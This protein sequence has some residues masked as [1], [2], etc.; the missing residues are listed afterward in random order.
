MAPS[1]RVGL[2]RKHD[3]RTEPPFIADDWVRCHHHPESLGELIDVVRH[4]S[5]LEKPFIRP[6]GSSWSL[7]EAVAN[8]DYEYTL[9]STHLLHET[10]DDVIPSCLT[11]AARD[12]LVGQQ[13]VPP[14]AAAEH[15]YTYY[16]VEAGCRIHDLYSRLDG[17]DPAWPTP[18]DG[19]S[20]GLRGPWAMPTLGGAGGQTIAGAISTS[21]HGGDQ[22]R[23]PIADAVAAIHLVAAGGMQFWIQRKK[24]SA[25]V[26]A[27]LC[28][29]TALQEVYRETSMQAGSKLEV[30]EDDRLFN[31]A[32]VAVGRMGVIYSYVLRVVHAYGLSEEREH[33]EWSE[34][35]RRLLDPADRLY[36]PWFLQVVVNPLPRVEF[37]FDPFQLGFAE[38]GHS[39]W[40]TTAE[41]I[42]VPEPLPEDGRNWLG[43]AQRAGS[44]AGRAP[45]VDNR[46]GDLYA[47]ACSTQ[48]PEVLLAATGAIATA[49]FLVSPIAPPFS[50]ILSGALGTTAGWLADLALRA[51]REGSSIGDAI[52]EI[53]NSAVADDKSWVLNLIAEAVIASGQAPTSRPHEDLGY[54]IQDRYNYDDVSCITSADSIEVAFDADTSAPVDFINTGVIPLARDLLDGRLTGNRQA[55]AGYASM[56]W[57]A[58]TEA[59]IG[60]QRWDRSCIIEVAGFKTFSGSGPYLDALEAH[61]KTMGGTVHWGQRN[62]L[63]RT[64]VNNAYASTIEDWRA[65]LRTLSAYGEPST[66]SSRYTE[67]AGLE[68]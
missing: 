40:I 56:R 54:A 10:L 4:D 6:V 19:L 55:F 8:R 16:H 27:P 23:P 62:S 42:A 51:E 7:S 2:R 17:Q 63:T 61:A 60:I 14:G 46:P 68:P 25:Q 33:A 58:K 12:H 41:T 45:P 47:L 20:P 5:S 34:V 9:V 3:V 30:I 65:A 49:A 57:T 31:A 1:D 66:F 38:R 13:E 59:L 22:H 11:P 67:R 53:G 64:D 44:S 21:T 52:A 24:V 29:A 15:N 26:E 48:T 50:F 36:Q 32:L 18:T 35:S 43:R 39:A 37:S 28:D